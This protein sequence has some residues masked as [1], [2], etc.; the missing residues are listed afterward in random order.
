M[1]NTVI[2]LT[3]EAYQVLNEK[4]DCLLNSAGLNHPVKQDEWLSNEDVMKLLKLSRSTLQLYRD[5]G[6]IP[7]SQIGRKLMYKLT[8]VNQV[9]DSFKIPAYS[10]LKNKSLVTF[11]NNK[12][13]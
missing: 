6:I 13:I 1:E 10:N 11:N 2:V 8:E 12:S 3:G 7:F 4:L 5:K 9:I